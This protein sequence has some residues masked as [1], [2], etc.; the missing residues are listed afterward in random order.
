MRYLHL[1]GYRDHLKP[2]KKRHGI[3]ENLALGTEPV[4]MSRTGSTV[5]RLLE[6]LDDGD[7]R[8]AALY[9]LGPRAECG[10]SIR[11]K[12]AVSTA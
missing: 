12:A 11:R 7:G 3:A 10:G 6:N 8:G 9:R 2:L 4:L 1:P 5:E